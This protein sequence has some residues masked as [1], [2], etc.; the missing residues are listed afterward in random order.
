MTD[1]YFIIHKKVLPDYFQKVIEIKEIVGRGANISDACKQ[2]GLSRSTFYKY[3]DYVDRPSMRAGKRIILSLKLVDEPG[4]LSNILNEI[5]S[6]NANILAIN[7]EVPIH[8]I[9]F[10]TLTIAILNANMSVQSFVQELKNGR[11]VID[12]LLVA[13]E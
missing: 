9:A 4:A 8:N 5:A 13:V 12:V 1:D 2:V 3:K 6:R 7:Q 11:N 10:V